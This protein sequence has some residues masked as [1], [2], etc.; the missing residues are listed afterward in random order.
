[1]N[2]NTKWQSSRDIFFSIPDLFSGDLQNAIETDLF[3]NPN[4]FASIS[5]PPNIYE[6]HNSNEIWVSINGTEMTLAEAILTKNLCGSAN[7]TTSY[8]NAPDPSH[9]AT[10]IEII[11][12]GQTE[13]LQDAINEGVFCVLNYG[14]WNFSKVAVLEAT[15][16]IQGSQPTDLFFK[17]DGEVLYTVDDLTN[18]IYQYTCSTPWDI[19]TCFYSGINMPLVNSAV[20][21]I[22]FKPDGTLLYGAETSYTRNITLST[23]SVPWDITTCY[24]SGTYFVTPYIGIL[25]SIFPSDLIFKPDGT[26]MYVVGHTSS[27]ISGSSYRKVQQYTCSTPWDITT[28]SYENIIFQ[29]LTTI[30]TG[31]LFFKPDGTELYETGDQSG[32]YPPKIYKYTCSTPWDIGTCTTINRYFEDTFTYDNI[33]PSQEVASRALFFKPDG[34]KLYE[35]GTQNDKVYQVGFTDPAFINLNGHTETDCINLPGYL[36]VFDTGVGY[37]CRISGASCPSGWSKY[38]EWSATTGN[39]VTMYEGPSPYGSTPGTFDRFDI[40]GHSFTNRIVEYCSHTSACTRGYSGTFQGTCSFTNTGG[41]ADYTCF[42][43]FTVYATQTEI[44]CI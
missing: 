37:M 19:T 31:G 10:E 7:P 43:L 15:L 33:I 29:A 21:G 16:S 24:Y 39:T 14:I 34:T 30:Y 23:C 12:D 5:S 28:C 27:S 38:Q 9:L 18:L 17:P 11:R 44:G 20:R 13:S 35:L 41:P 40:P 32:A 8:I 42:Q 36:E 4:I 26:K 6:G 3:N 22:F 25:D 1:V 2:K